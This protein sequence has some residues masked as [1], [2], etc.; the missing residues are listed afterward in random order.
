MGPCV[1]AGCLNQSP[2]MRT[3]IFICR[4]VL[5]A[6]SWRC[7]LLVILLCLLPSGSTIQ[8]IVKCA[9]LSVFFTISK[10]LDDGLPVNIVIMLWSP[11]LRIQWITKLF[12]WQVKSIFGVNRYFTTIYHLICSSISLEWCN[13]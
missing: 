4:P 1:R 8:L 10:K 11:N 5:G 3:L 6:W 9:L 2:T 7:F 12:F 13:Q